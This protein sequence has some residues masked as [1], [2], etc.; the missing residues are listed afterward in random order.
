MENHAGFAAEAGKVW[1]WQK[2]LHQGL[3]GPFADL[4]ST[5]QKR[6]IA[7]VLSI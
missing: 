2:L 6:G 5:L 3:R 7:C 4:V 1:L